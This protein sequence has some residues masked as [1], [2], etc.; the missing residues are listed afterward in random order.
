MTEQTCPTCG[1][2]GYYAALNTGHPVR[3]GC[4]AEPPITPS[5]DVSADE[6]DDRAFAAW[7]DSRRADLRAKGHDDYVTAAEE[8]WALNAWDAALAHARRNQQTDEAIRA[9]LHDLEGQLPCSDETCGC[10]GAIWPRVRRV[11][12]LLDARRSR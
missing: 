7:I 11:L 1:G 6:D 9:A 10:C 4:K 3:C 5:P 8:G 2:D 12:E